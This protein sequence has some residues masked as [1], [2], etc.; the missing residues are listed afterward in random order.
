MSQVK[1]KWDKIVKR[2][3]AAV[4]RILR[5]LEPIQNYSYVA[6]SLY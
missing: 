1:K 3:N 2:A 4:V 6:K 5:I